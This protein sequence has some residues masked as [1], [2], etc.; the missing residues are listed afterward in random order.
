M[1]QVMKE[2]DGYDLQIT[3]SFRVHVSINRN[4][5]NVWRTRY[6]SSL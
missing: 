1:V 4:G 6:G 5:H 2:T 3:S